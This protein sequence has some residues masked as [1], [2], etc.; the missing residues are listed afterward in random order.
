MFRPDRWWV[1]SSIST[2]S[3]DKRLEAL[4]RDAYLDLPDLKYVLLLMADHHPR[5]SFVQ[6]QLPKTLSETET[7]FLPLAEM[8]GLWGLRRS[9][10]E[11]LVRHQ[12]PATYKQAKD[13]F[14][15]HASARH[16][17]CA[18]LSQAFGESARAERL[19]PVPR[20]QPTDTLLGSDLMPL[21]ERVHREESP[22]R[23][24]IRVFC[25][26]VRHCYAA[27]G[28]IHKLGRPVAP[29]YS[30]RFDDY[31]ASPHANGYQALHTAIM[32]TYDNERGHTKH[33]LCE[34]R[35]L[36][37][38]MHRLNEWGAIAALYQRP[39]LHQLTLA[40]WNQTGELSRL[41]CNRYARVD[42]RLLAHADLRD[43]YSY[44]L[45]YPV[46]LKEF[47]TRFPV[48][49]A[50]T[51]LYV[52]TPRGELFF[53]DEHATALDFAY[54]IHTDVG[55]QAHRIEVNDEPAA[56]DRR[57]RNGDRV[58]IF[59]SPGAAGPDLPW[60][61]W[62]SSRHAQTK[63][64]RHLTARARVIH[65]GRFQIEEALLNRARY[66]KQR[67]NYEPTLERRYLD[68]FL[69]RAVRRQQLADMNTLYNL[70]S[71]GQMTADSLARR[72]I[73]EELAAALVDAHGD[74]LPYSLNQIIFCDTCRP[75]PGSELVAYLR[76]ARTAEVQLVVHTTICQCEKGGGQ[77]AFL[78][79]ADPHS[80]RALIDIDIL[81]EDRLR[82][83]G[84][85]LE[86]L[87]E[88][89][90]IYVH[91]VAAETH[92]DGKADI[93]FSVRV[94]GFEQLTSLQARM[95]RIAGVR[96]VFHYPAS[97]GQ[98]LALE[99]PSTGQV[100]N[101]YS[102]DEVYTIGSFYDRETLINDIVMWLMG[103]LP[104]T[105]LI[106]HGQRR[107]GKSSLLLYLTREILPR[108]P[109]AVPVLLDLQN[110]SGRI[111]MAQLADY[112]LREVC[113]ALPRHAHLVDER[114]RDEEPASWLNRNLESIVG[115][116]EDR[117]LLL[118][119]DEFDVLMDKDAVQG[120]DVRIFDNLRA[121]ITQRSDI[122]WLL[123]VS[124]VHYSDPESW[125]HAGRLLQK[126]TS[127]VVPN[128]DIQWAYKLI[129][130]PIRNCG[131]VIAD[132]NPLECARCVAQL[133]N[134]TSC[135]YCL[136]RAIFQLTAGNPYFIQI[137]CHELVDR[138]R[139]Q[140]RTRI[141]AKDLEYVVQ[142]ALNDG[143]RC[144]DHFLRNLGDSR[145]RAVLAAIAANSRPGEW[146]DRSVP[147]S[148]L[149]QTAQAFSAEAVQVTL[150]A[151]ARLGVIEVKADHVR[152]SHGLFHRWV[153]TYWPLSD[154]LS[155][156]SYF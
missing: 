156:P 142:L 118:M 135:E 28:I 101:P 4:F 5:L 6:T 22:C 27:L 105:M 17:A 84:D 30:L 15:G 136:P 96:Q 88:E 60:L 58:R 8:L 63:I 133:E 148:L 7:I 39:R 62:V 109:L 53:L 95:E 99:V 92:G 141:E 76:V 33:M 144:F 67:R 78:R 72:L 31:I 119:I 103:P 139:R 69:V 85:I 152:M 57:L 46:T 20:I 64:R 42:S 151:L 110:I 155:L 74:R 32:Y 114:A 65:E 98:A 128:L 24:V 149:V 115:E 44:L 117:R 77:P 2:P 40:W 121:V 123:V 79:W 138:V 147:T 36:T 68:D 10:M 124:D 1:E 113:L 12:A 127:L 90:D 29:K 18:S 97:P 19:C 9:W 145:R 122:N 73:S 34:V 126:G 59:V 120:V 23:L 131:L 132:D 75:A 130:E 146:I 45:P 11:I 104:S 129:L 134:P 89:P 100:R 50:S 61:S 21:D 108:K 16:D 140:K 54:H 86:G 25:Q 3:P 83:L 38:A 111:E 47:L 41:L 91:R 37:P 137:L 154:V 43:E 56:F 106:L 82:L 51:P 81:A 26:T 93:H 107:V 80:T 48:G 116:L 14:A 94:E 35:I 112:I 87:Y 52:F 153:A 49:T 71:G 66:Y 13:S 70:V 55:S 102:L 125:P 143:K 150:Q